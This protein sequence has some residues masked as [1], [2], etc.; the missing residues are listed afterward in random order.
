MALLELRC[1]INRPVAE[2]LTSQTNLKRNVLI[3]ILEE[4]LQGFKK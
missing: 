4:L 3:R 1:G 2:N